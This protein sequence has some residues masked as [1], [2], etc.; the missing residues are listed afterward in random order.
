MHCAT[1]LI[2]CLAGDGFTRLCPAWR[3]TVW[4]SESNLA[5]SAGCRHT[6]YQSPGLCYNSD[7]WWSYY[8]FCLFVC[9]TDS[10]QVS[11]PAMSGKV[12]QS[13]AQLARLVVE[14]KHKTKSGQHLAGTG[15]E[16][17]HHAGWPH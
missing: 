7:E 2:L 9:V 13:A 16:A 17:G 4:Q 11:Q 3:P 15:E 1:A 6:G 14:M 5:V 12:M 10:T 8:E